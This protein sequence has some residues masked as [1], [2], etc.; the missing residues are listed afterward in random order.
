MGEEKP[1]SENGLGENIEDSISDNLGVNVNVAGS[2]SD[3]PDAMTSQCVSQARSRHANLHWVDGPEHQGESG[4]GAEESSSL[5]VLVLNHTTAIEGKLVNNDQIGNTSHGI[6]SPFGTLFN[7]E[8]SEETG[9]D[10][11]HIS[12]NGN[13]DVGTVQ[14]SEQGKV[15]E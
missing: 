7:G 11:D 14:S 3:T 8:G 15:Q 9:Q 5:L 4:D 1:E 13:E 12:D 10:H 6:P 2:I